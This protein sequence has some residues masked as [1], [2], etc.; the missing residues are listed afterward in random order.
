MYI[1]EFVKRIAE[2]RID[3]FSILAQ[4]L[5]ISPQVSFADICDFQHVQY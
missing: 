1:L 2:G 3:S 4:N 5:Q